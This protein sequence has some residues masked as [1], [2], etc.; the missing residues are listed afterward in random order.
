[1]KKLTLAAGAI[2][3]V[4]ITQAGAFAISEQSLR[5]YILK[6]IDVLYRDRKLGGYDPGRRFTQ[7]LSYG[8]SCCVKASRPVPQKPPYPTMCVAA[9]VETMIEALDLYGK[10]TGDLSF[11]DSFPLS[12]VDGS[13]RTALI[14]NVFKYSGSDSAGTGYALALLG[15]GREIPFNKLQPGDFITFNRLNGTGHAVIFL[16]YL[17]AATTYPSNTFSSQVVGFRYFSAQGQKR[18]DGGFGFRN[19]YFAG[20]CPSPKGKD[21]DCNVIGLTVKPDGAVN[22]SPRLFN[23][24]EM[25]AP[26][27]W[28]IQGAIDRLRSNVA[29]GFEQEGLTRGAGLEEAVQFELTRELHADAAVFEDGSEP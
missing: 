13:T 1:M 14:P 9:V 3:S 24:G 22:Q 25:F 28:D 5:P 12:R 23:S 8:P 10:A 27:S 20:K 18:A 11:V 15:L 6:A 7:D 17:T 4:M 19:A 2:A 26:P 29:K 16:G 21:D